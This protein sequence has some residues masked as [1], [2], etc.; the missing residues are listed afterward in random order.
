MCCH[1]YLPHCI[2]SSLYQAQDVAWKITTNQEMETMGSQCS[3]LLEF[4]FVENQLENSPN[5]TVENF[6]LVD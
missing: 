1:Y 6:P 4:G 5:I 2:S 3:D